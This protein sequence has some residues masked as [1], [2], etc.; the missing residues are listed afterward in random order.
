MELLLDGV[1]I[2]WQETDGGAEI[3]RVWPPVSRVVL[4]EMIEG[5]AVVALGSRAFSPRGD[6]EMAAA[7][8]LRAVSLPKYLHRVGDYAFYNCTALEK[9]E[10]YDAAQHWGVGCLMNCRALGRIELSVCEPHSTAL[11]YFAQELSRELDVSIYDEA[12]DLRLIFP[13]FSEDYENNDPAHH[14]DFRLYGAGYPYHEAFWEKELSLSLF[15][16]AWS[17]MMRRGHDADCALRL[18]WYRLHFPRGLAPAAEKQYRAYLSERRSALLLWALRAGRE[19]LKET[20]AAFPPQRDDLAAALEYARREGL[21]E[22]LALLLDEQHRRFG[23]SGRRS[24][25]L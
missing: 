6:E 3:T 12:G 22:Q 1:T 21:R 20:L 23:A 7:R 11:Y 9:L 25:E 16:G 2:T 17:G 15:D 13:E 4:P 24:F 14:F 5:R 10:L 19:E 18:A 8:V